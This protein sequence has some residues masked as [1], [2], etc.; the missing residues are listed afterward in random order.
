MLKSPIMAVDL[1]ISPL[2]SV[3]FCCT[4]TVHDSFH[5]LGELFFLTCVATFFT[6]INIDCALDSIFF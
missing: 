2:D 5:A 3:K 1:T 4:R 6:P